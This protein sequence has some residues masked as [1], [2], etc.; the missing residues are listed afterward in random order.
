MIG[1]EAVVIAELSL[2]EIMRRPERTEIRITPDVVLRGEEKT[3][4]YG[5][6]IRSMNKT[7]KD[8]W[9]TGH[10]VTRIQ[11]E[12]PTVTPKVCRVTTLILLN[13]LSEP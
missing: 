7:L 4:D 1:I 8:A 2:Y 10:I 5:D 12:G 9:V 13:A 3:L 11:A 6:Q